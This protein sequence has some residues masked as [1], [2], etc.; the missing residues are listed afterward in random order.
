MY[1][2][3]G[4]PLGIST[5]LEHKLEN[6]LKKYPWVNLISITD[7]CVLGPQLP[8]KTFNCI[9]KV[10]KNIFSIA[11]NVNVAFA[12]ISPSCSRLF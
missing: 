12:P 5:W 8:P 7:M 6:V 1:K 9:L 10:S 4:N 2:N 11:A 3:Q